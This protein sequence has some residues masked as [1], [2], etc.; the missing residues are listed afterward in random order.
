MH[1]PLAH[2]VEPCEKAIADRRAEIARVMA[3]IAMRRERLAGWIR[4]GSIDNGDAQMRNKRM[5]GILGER[6]SI[7][8]DLDDA[9]KIE[10]LSKTHFHGTSWQALMQCTPYFEVKH[11]VT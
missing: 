10:A 1:P 7:F 8:M 3:N 4:S 5:P 11:E 9:A 6:W 2:T